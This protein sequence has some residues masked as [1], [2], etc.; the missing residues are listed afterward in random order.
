MTIE[1]FTKMFRDTE[2]VAVV[3]KGASVTY[4]DRNGD[5]VPIVHGNFHFELREKKLTE[6]EVHKDEAN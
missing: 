4:E 3:D 1:E 6:S 5:H 2:I